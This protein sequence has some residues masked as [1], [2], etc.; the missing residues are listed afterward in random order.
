MC[1]HLGHAALVIVTLFVW[2]A[3]PTLAQSPSHV[4][5]RCPA[6]YRFFETVCASRSGGDVAN[7]A[8]AASARIAEEQRC[9][10]GY[11]RIEEVCIS[12]NTG[13]V[14]LVEEQQMMARKASSHGR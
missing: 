10:P 3:P 5:E 12:K 6:D 4:D 11:W 14:E 13:D 7:V 8:P 1:A 9:A 2:W